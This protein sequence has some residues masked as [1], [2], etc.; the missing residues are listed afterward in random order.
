LIVLFSLLSVGIVMAIPHLGS[1]IV[2]AA[3]LGV[4]G[5]LLWALRPVIVSAAMSEAPQQLSGSI[6]ALIYGANMGLSFLAPLVAGIVA[7][8]YGLP[9][10]VTAIAIFPMLASLICFVLLVQR[11]S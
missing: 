9:T 2:L 4:L 10:A 11:R 6:V 1:G 5:A 8:A 3:G 7:D